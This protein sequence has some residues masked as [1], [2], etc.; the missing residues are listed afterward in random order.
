MT[1]LIND[2]KF[3]S[4]SDD[5][6]P[7]MKFLADFPHVLHEHSKCIMGPDS[8]FGETRIDHVSTSCSTS[9]MDVEPPDKKDVREGK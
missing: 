9:S 6:G 5:V 1:A 8:M 2:R 3:K 7:L 4:S